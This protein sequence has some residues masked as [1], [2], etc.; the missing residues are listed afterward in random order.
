LEK[1]AVIFPNR[2]VAEF[3]W[4]IFEKISNAAN[5]MKIP[6]IGDEL[7]RADRPTEN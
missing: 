2:N 4:Q 7:F 6:A 5:F 1:T 3:S